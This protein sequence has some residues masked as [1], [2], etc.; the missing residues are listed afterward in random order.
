MG[1]CLEYLCTAW[2]ELSQERLEALRK[3]IT[4]KG[5]YWCDIERVGS[6]HTSG[7]YKVTTGKSHWSVHDEIADVLAV[8]DDVVEYSDNGLGSEDVTNDIFNHM[9]R[10]NPSGL[11]YTGPEPSK[12]QLEI[13][14]KLR[15]EEDQ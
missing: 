15:Y 8:F 13:R 11:V 12:E 9:R 4:S 1:I 5:K 10:P 7:L 2:P 3:K 6:V 14:E